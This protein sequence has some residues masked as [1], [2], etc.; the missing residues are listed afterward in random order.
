MKKK[1][2]KKIQAD[3]IIA[4]SAMLVS[5][6]TLILFV[7]Q[8]SLQHNESRLSVAPRISFSQEYG[9]RIEN[10][11]SS[12][13]T[14]SNKFIIYNIFLENKGLGPA[15]LKSVDFLYQDK[16][17][18]IESFIQKN[19]KF[20][21][22]LKIDEITSFSDGAILSKNE[23]VKLFELS[24]KKIDEHQFYNLANIKKLEE[25]IEISVVYESLYEEVYKKSS[26]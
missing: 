2:K 5:L 23:K 4:I 11:I 13:D 9:T 8:I 15:I 26:K 3:K 14:I 18:E 12:Q 19:Q 6:L 7:Y 20:R 10:I 1:R 21:N 25:L 24:V 16:K 17:I 22:L